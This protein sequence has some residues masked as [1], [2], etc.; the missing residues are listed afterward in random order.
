MEMSEG[1]FS[2]GCYPGSVQKRNVN[3]KPLVVYI[4]VS[5]VF[6]PRQMFVNW[7]TYQKKMDQKKNQQKNEVLGDR[8]VFAT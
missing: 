8:S 4:V 7:E 3:Q 5:T 1:P 2:A 6:L